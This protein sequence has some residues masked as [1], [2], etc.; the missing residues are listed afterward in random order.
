MDGAIYNRFW[1]AVKTLKITSSGSQLYLQLLGGRPVGSRI[2]LWSPGAPGNMVPETLC[3]QPLNS[4]SAKL[5]VWAGLVV[6]NWNTT[7]G[8]ADFLTR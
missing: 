4:F 5:S 2:L 3:I 8:D 6:P 7:R 1:R